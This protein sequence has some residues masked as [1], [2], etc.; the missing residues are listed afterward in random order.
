[1]ISCGE[2]SGDLYGAALA[3]EIL[4]LEPSAEIIGF[5]GDRLHDAGARLVGHFSGLSVTGILEVAR[6]LPRTYETYRRLVAEAETTPPDVF[7][8]IDFP[9]FNFALARA[10]RKRGIPVVYYISP[11][12]W[13]WRRGRMKTMKRLADRVLVIF[14][15]EEKI[16]RDAGV[17]V[18]WVGH[19]LLDLA[20]KPESR[21]GFLTRHG[22]DGDR[23]VVALLPGSRRNELRAILPDLARAAALIRARLPAVQFIVAR[24]PHL[25]DDLFSP[26][27]TLRS[28][29]AAV[30]VVEGLAD[31]VL[32]SA[33]VALV[34]SGT[35]TVQAA[36][37]ECP[38]VVVYRLSQLTY[39]LG[40][41]FVHVDTYAMVNLVAGARIVP[42]L[43]QDAFTPDAVAKEA[44]T[45]L[46]DPDHASRLRAQLRDVKS[47]LGEPGASRRAAIAVLDVAR[48]A[49]RQSLG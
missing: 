19:P 46:T 5:G 41:P 8:A 28:G 34:A 48:A 1:M 40:K 26:L 39:G 11:Q 38:M 44:L 49:S 43:I 16:Y 45:V 6:L 10:M 42:E 24:A 9:D 23:P 13:A 21:R 29:G 35:V 31:D 37:H 17:P 14:P 12:L 3:T 25:A 22:L 20:R 2:P 47:R 4:Q 32:A 18:Q 27:E 7:V 36:L 33:D 30:T 15:F